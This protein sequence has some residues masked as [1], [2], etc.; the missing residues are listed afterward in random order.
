M[1]GFRKGLRGLVPE[2]VLV[3]LTTVLIVVVALIGWT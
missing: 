2:A 1:I 3:P